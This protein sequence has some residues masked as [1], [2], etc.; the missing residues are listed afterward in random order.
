M[1][2]NSQIAETLK[3]SVGVR[4]QEPPYATLARGIVSPDGTVVVAFA[5][6]SNT[7]V[8]AN[9]NVVGVG[10]TKTACVAATTAN[11]TIATALN[12]GDTLDT[13]V[14]LAT[15]DRVL[16][17]NQTDTTENGIYIVAVSPSRALDFDNWAEIPGAI[18]SVT[19]GTANAGTSYM[20]NGA[21]TGV[22]GT[23]SIVFTPYPN[24]AG[25]TSPV[26]TT[27]IVAASTTMALFNTVA[28]TIN[29][30]AAASSAINIGHA[31]GT[32]TILGTVAYGGNITFA[33]ETAH[34]V[35]VTDTTTSATAGAAYSIT[36]AAGVTSGAGGAITVT[37]GAGGTTGLGG[38]VSLIGG[39]GGTTSGA[40]GAAALRGGAGG[41]AGTGA[42]GAASLVGGA[43]GTGATG[44]G[45]AVSVTGGAASST[46][47][48]GGAVTKTGGAGAGTGDG[49]AVASVGGAGGAT[50]GVGGAV[51]L[52]GGAGGTSAGVGG[53]I[54]LT[55]GT[56]VAA[57][58]AGGAITI[59]GG[60]STT[61]AAG[62]VVALVGGSVGTTGIGGAITIT[63][64][65]SG[66]SGARNGGAVTLAGGACGA[67]S[68][69]AGGAATIIGGA[70]GSGATGKGGLVAI[71]GG[72][73]GS[74]NDD[75]GSIVITPGAKSGTGIAGIIRNVG[76]VTRNAASTTF[77]DTGTLAVSNILSGTVKCT[78]TAAAT[79]TMPTGAVIAA[80]LP[81]S[82]VTGDSI[83]FCLVNVATN[84]SYDITVATAASG[85]T[86]Y[87]CL[88]VSSNAAVTDIS[89]GIFRIICTGAGT[90]DVFRIS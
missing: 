11:I 41:T 61:S 32:V 8:D 20:A 40:G 63:G 69:G 65:V 75:G 37:S 49:G 62:G 57:A 16:V 34:T 13:S 88:Q 87:G 15:G 81:T 85:T 64:G 24:G 79:Y 55:G 53:A 36:G 51:T 19:S 70:S 82:F 50:S 47:G 67:G 71:T 17:K 78:P 58:T 80:A 66:T 86:M 35:T 22:V 7:L 6:L 30:G 90:Y 2:Q 54:T 29:F 46:N 39:V 14:T 44:A 76:P 74:T 4:S 42:G 77:T 43:S 52:A 72:A 23:D 9:G 28:T 12:N 10:K 48:A 33:K 83:D 56:P 1:S 31:S 21:A 3:T 89:S 60:T 5:G 73:S 68:T 59:T 26:F 84:S 18:V 27:G 45:G 25:F 38:A